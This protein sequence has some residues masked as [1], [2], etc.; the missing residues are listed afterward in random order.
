MPNV[1]FLREGKKIE[2]EEGANLRKAAMDAGISV[3]HG[4]EKVA[5]C[6]GFGLCGTCMVYV[7]EGEENCSDKGLVE[8][9]NLGLHPRSL[10][11]SVGHEKEARLAC[12][13]QVYDDI[14][15]DTKPQMNLHGQE[16][17]YEKRLEGEQYVEFPEHAPRGVREKQERA[18]KGVEKDWFHEKRAVKK[19]EQ[20]V[21]APPS[22][23][24]E[25]A[26]DESGE[27]EADEDE[28]DEDSEQE[29]D[30]DQP[31]EQKSEKQGSPDEQDG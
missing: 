14:V 23:V 9:L 18:E 31:Q 8:S 27:G 26:E 11:Y 3:Y 1:T 15:V 20:E 28:S 30:Q 24:E 13:M 2:V 4:I 12:Q 7:K 10:L 21:E 19:K 17:A 25:D 6:W 5:N 16:H 22:E 29:Q